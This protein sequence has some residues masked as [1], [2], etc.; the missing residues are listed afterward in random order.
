MIRIE[1]GKKSYRTDT[2]Q[3]TALNDVSLHIKKG[4]FVSISGS[5][6][7]GKSLLFSLC[8]G[9]LDPTDGDVKLDGHSLFIQEE[10]FFYSNFFLH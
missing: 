5:S 9:L 4:E 6:G 2:I 3:T 7:S 8:S 1:R 10:I